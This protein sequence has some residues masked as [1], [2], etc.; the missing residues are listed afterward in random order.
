[1]PDSGTVPLFLFAKEPLAGKVKTRMRPCLS[2]EDC[3][4]LARQMLEQT[5]EKACLHWPG[6]VVLCAAP[7]PGSPLFRTLSSHHGIA[8]QICN[9]GR[10][11]RHWEFPNLAAEKMFELLDYRSDN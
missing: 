10:S 5:L 1:M 11:V 3:A 7:D 9:L 6:E 4:R 8:S 2:G